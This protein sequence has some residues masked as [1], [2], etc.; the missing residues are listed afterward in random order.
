M[1][2]STKGIDITRYE[3][4]EFGMAELFADIFGEEIRHVILE[5]QYYHYRSQ[6]RTRIRMCPEDCP[7]P[8]GMPDHIGLQKHAEST[9]SAIGYYGG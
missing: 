7:Q 1:K 3:L 2:I 8:T 6:L 4:S 9:E 5:R